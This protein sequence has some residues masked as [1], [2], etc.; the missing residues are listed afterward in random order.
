MCSLLQNSRKSPRLTKTQALAKAVMDWNPQLI[1][2]LCAKAQR[3][4]API[5]HW[6]KPAPW[7]NRK[8][9]LFIPVHN[10]ALYVIYVYFIFVYV[11]L[12]FIFFYDLCFFLFCFKFHLLCMKKGELE[13]WS[14]LQP[15]LWLSL[16]WV[17]AELELWDY[18]WLQQSRHL[19]A[20]EQAQNLYVHIECLF[21]SQILRFSKPL[22]LCC[23]FRDIL[24]RLE[25]LR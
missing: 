24:R 5:D 15:W 18:N 9:L 1:L 16:Q 19:T 21:D 7:N 10:I 2:A 14:G 11:C 13:H 4:Q 23:F 6:K 8:A 12:W 17:T 22:S 3:S 20:G 25:K